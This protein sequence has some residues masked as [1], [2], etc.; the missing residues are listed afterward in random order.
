MIFTFGFL[1]ATAT[2]LVCVPVLI[3]VTVVRSVV[4]HC[5]SC[6]LHILSR[7]FIV[8][9]YKRKFKSWLIHISNPTDPDQYNKA[10]TRQKMSA[11]RGHRTLNP[12]PNLSRSR[13][14]ASGSWLVIYY[15]LAPNSVIHSGQ[16]TVIRD[17]LDSG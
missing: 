11:L 17:P 14:R 9:S 6:R 10:P 5:S 1:S 7:R 3:A 16:C 4:L 15:Q 8:G 2:P 13:G 12:V